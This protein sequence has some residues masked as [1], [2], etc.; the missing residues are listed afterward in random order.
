MGAQ[1]SILPSLL[2][3]SFSKAAISKYLLLSSSALSSPFGSRAGGQLKPSLPIFCSSFLVLPTIISSLIL[4][5][6][7][8]I[9][10]YF[11]LALRIPVKAFPCYAVHKF[12]QYVSFTVLSSFPHLS[13][14]WTLFILSISFFQTI[15]KIRTPFSHLH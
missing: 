2:V 12:S 3:C 8:F 14:H 13:L 10:H 9:Y 1:D 6:V 4:V 5:S 15:S 7:H 11:Y